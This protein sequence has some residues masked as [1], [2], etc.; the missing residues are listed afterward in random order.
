MANT[1]QPTELHLQNKEAE[2]AIIGAIIIDGQVD[3]EAFVAVRALLNPG[4]FFNETLRRIYFALCELKQGID[5]I[6]VINRLKE[7]GKFQDGDDA[8]VYWCIQNTPTPY[9]CE[10]HAR[11]V[12]DLSHRR[13]AIT[14]AQYALKHAMTGRLEEIKGGVIL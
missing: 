3:G 9:H 11:I 5:E 4:D 12:K 14:D 13:R 1:R 7:S 10:Y 8:A 2:A 6:T